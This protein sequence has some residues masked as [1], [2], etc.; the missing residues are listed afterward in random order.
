[1]KLFSESAELGNLN[2]AL[3]MGMYYQNIQPDFGRSVYYLTLPTAEM[4]D[5]AQCMVGVMYF[6]GGPG[7]K[8]NHDKGRH[9]L[10]LSAAQGDHEAL[11]LLGRIL[12]ASDTK[13]EQEEGIAFLKESALQMN[14][15]AICDLGVIYYEG[16]ITK[17]SYERAFHYFDCAAQHGCKQAMYMLSGLFKRGHGCAQSQELAQEWFIKAETNADES[18]RTHVADWFQEHEC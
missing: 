1:V 6:N 4:N 5:R 12:R 17:Q 16:S 8:L 10:R 13:T 11:Y 18:I 2:S 9:Y 3:F 14:T 15:A 7:L